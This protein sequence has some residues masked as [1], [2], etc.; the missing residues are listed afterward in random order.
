MMQE[1]INERCRR[2]ASECHVT[3]SYSG[4]RYSFGAQ[5][6]SFVLVTQML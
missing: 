2:L 6:L 3:L 1:T 5:C 4:V